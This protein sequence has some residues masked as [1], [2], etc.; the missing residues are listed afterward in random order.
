MNICPKCGYGADWRGYLKKAPG[1]KVHFYSSNGAAV[2]RTR[3]HFKL[4]MPFDDIHAAMT[5][6]QIEHQY[7]PFFKWC[8]VPDGSID[9]VIANLKRR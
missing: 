6:I 4:T 8:D 3:L 7:D 1:Y 5:L 2:A 9:S